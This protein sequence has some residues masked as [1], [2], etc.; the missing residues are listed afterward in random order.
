MKGGVRGQLREIRRLKAGLQDVRFSIP[1]QGM[2]ARLDG[3]PTTI[4]GST[5]GDVLR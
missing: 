2:A 1:T 4:V 3:F 5:L